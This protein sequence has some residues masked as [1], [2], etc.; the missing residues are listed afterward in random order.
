MCEWVEFCPS[1]GKS[2][3]D[4]PCRVLTYDFSSQTSEILSPTEKVVAKELDRDTAMIATIT[5]AL[6][7]AN[8]KST[9]KGTV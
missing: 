7:R 4:A 5:E 8:E 9:Y 2:I 3:E 6:K 1:T